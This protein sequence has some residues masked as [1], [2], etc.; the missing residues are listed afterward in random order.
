M[1]L[2]SKFQNKK[3]YSILSNSRSILAT[4]VVRFSSILFKPFKTN[5]SPVSVLTFY[6]CE[7]AM[8]T[9]VYS[10]SL[11]LGDLNDPIQIL[12]E[13]RGKTRAGKI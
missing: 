9:N 5:F 3:S 1:V 11:V 12:R 4:G 8:P 10:S 2:L 13:Q 7:I 6:H